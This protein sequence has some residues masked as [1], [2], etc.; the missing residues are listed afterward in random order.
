M[1]KILSVI[2]SMALIL[3]VVSITTVSA[4]ATPTI[5]VSNVLGNREQV[6]SVNIKINNNPGILAMAFCVQYDSNAFEYKGYRSGYLTDYNIMD[7]A[8][9]GYVSFVSVEKNDV[10]KNGTVL[11][12][13]FA[14]KPTAEFGRYDISI[15]NNNP[16]KYGDSLHNSFAN[17]AEDFILPVVSNGSITVTE[18]LILMSGDVNSDNNINNKDLGLLMQY[19]NNWDVQ[20]NVYA[21]DVNDDDAVNNK[22][23][24]LLMQ[25]V[26]NWD[27]ELQ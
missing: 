17:S 22:D 26:N 20:I 13:S 8:D 16:E 2:I 11:T 23:Y 1:K 25:Y 18:E 5:T 3:S 6:V 10:A 4:V 12:I 9:K 14:V 27:V 7:H 19:I 21:A 15:L 24:G